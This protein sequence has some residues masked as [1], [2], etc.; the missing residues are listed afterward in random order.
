MKVIVT[1]GT[2]FLG[3]EILRQCVANPEITSI[4]AL[5]RRDLSQ[6]WQ[7]EKKITTLKIKDFGTYS[8]EDLKVL[9][10]AEGC[11]WA[12]GTTP[13][14]ARHMTNEELKTVNE[15]W[16]TNAAK[17]WSQWPLPDGKVFRFVFT[18]GSLVPSP[19]DLDQKLWFG[20]YMRKGRA[21]TE[22]NLL[23]IA[24][25]GKLDAYVAKPGFITTGT[26]LFGRL[27]FGKW[28]VSK[29]AMTAGYLDLLLHGNEKKVF[30]NDDLRH[31]GA[32]AQKKFAAKK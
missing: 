16:P 27:T 14:K 4:I 1:G 3:A 32:E 29:E 24:K 10:G 13:D 18:S 25:E 11:F 20:E 23:G 17:A 28:W 30:W 15:D 21:Y 19:E 8:P 6:E 7:A 5:A 26:P 22:Q 9:E 31:L 2:G 12:L